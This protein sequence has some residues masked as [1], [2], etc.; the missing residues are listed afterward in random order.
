M[1]QSPRS[2]TS[3]PATP[4]VENPSWTSTKRGQWGLVL[5]AEAVG[6]IVMT[7]LL[8]RLPL[9]WPLRQ[10]MVGVAVMGIPLCL[11][12]VRPET[13]IIGVGALLA[14]AGTEVFGTGW[15]VALMEQIP[16][17]ALS[18]VA[19]FDMLGSFLAIPAGTLLYG[20]LASAADLET[21]LIVSAVVY[22]VVTLVTLLVPSIRRLPRLGDSQAAPDQDLAKESRPPRE[23]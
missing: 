2:A 20:W 23:A 21:V 9:N 3:A 8:M 13:L 17:E 16:Q 4:T 11:L 7:V 14:G 19:S 22:A 1:P 18:R 12:G 5:S 10:G 6:A 15:N